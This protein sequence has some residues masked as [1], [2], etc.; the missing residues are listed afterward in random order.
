MIF[1]RNK[2]FPNLST[3]LG[4]EQKHT[5]ISLSLGLL[6]AHS[7]LKK[8]S[9]QTFIKLAEFLKRVLL[10]L[11]KICV[12]INIKGIPKFLKD[13]LLEIMKKSN[14]LVFNPITESLQ[15][16]SVASATGVIFTKIHYYKTF[17]Y[18]ATKS[19]KLGRVKRKIRRKIL[20][21]NNVID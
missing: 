12:I 21:V 17:N 13:V 5:E 8:Q 16:Q 19:K 9:K 15:P 10:S 2:F 20:A 11:E 1:K 18:A 4:L 14:K 7:K 6:R 3:S